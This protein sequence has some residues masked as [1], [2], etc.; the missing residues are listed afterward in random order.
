MT[1][2]AELR[3]QLT[4]KGYV[5]ELSSNPVLTVHTHPLI[6]NPVVLIGIDS[7]TAREYQNTLV[8]EAIKRR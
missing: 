1:T 8:S 2:L 5:T 3:A 6:T 4:A 7:E